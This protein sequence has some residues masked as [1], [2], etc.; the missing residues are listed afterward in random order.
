[1]M[2]VC[3]C[4][5]NAKKQM[6]INSQNFELFFGWTAPRH[7]CATSRKLIPFDLQNAFHQRFYDCFLQHSLF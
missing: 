3:V 2:N 5:Q 4:A 1:M 7:D 6:D